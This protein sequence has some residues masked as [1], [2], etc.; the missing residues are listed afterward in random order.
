MVNGGSLKGMGSGMGLEVPRDVQA[1]R[2]HEGVGRTGRVTQARGLWSGNESHLWL[3]GSSAPLQTW[4]ANH[5]AA[6]L[7]LCSWEPLSEPFA[8]AAVCLSVSLRLSAGGGLCA[9]GVRSR[10]ASSLG[11]VDAVS[12]WPYVPVPKAD[13]SVPSALGSR[14]R[15]SAWKPKA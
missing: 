13:S 5:R 7:P 1:G 3:R 4:A 11:F 6:Q 2:P 14:D 8:S 12:F 9:P 15:S 10:E